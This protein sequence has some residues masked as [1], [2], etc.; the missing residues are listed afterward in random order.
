MLFKG[1]FFTVLGSLLGAS[2]FLTSCMNTSTDFDWQGHRGARGLLPENSLPAFEKALELGMRT[3]E[4]DVAISQDNQ[5]VVSHEPWMSATICSHPDGRPVQEAEEDSLLLY[6]LSLEELQKFDCG[7]RPHPRFPEQKKV[8]VYKPSL[9]EVIQMAEKYVQ[10]KGREAVYYNIEIKSKPS[11]DGTHTPPPAEFA[12]LLMQLLQKEGV[13]QRSCIQSFDKRP[14]QYLH[15]KYP[16]QVLAFLSE[17]GEAATEIEE[18]GFTPPVYSPYYPTVDTEMM[19][20]C[21]KKG[22]RCIPWTVNTTKE[23]QDLIDLGVDGI[24]T[25][26]PNRIPQ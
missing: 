13:A 7:L 5:V 24:I 14:L 21:K 15:E 9:S 17:T 3:L 4:L 19:A 23:M 18:L 25:D 11:W 1:S 16:Q 2:L 10:E 8:A 20:F 26:Y 6:A 12:E 22:M